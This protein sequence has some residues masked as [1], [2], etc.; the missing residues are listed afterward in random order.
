MNKKKLLLYAVSLFLIGL[1]SCH[2]N[3][4]ASTV[5]PKTWNSNKDV[6]ESVQPGDDFYNYA[7]G[8]WLKANPLKDE[9]PSNGTND[10]LTALDNTRYNNLMSNPSDNFLVNINKSI[11]NTDLTE[12]NS[13]DEV[14][15]DLALIQNANTEQ[16]V[17]INMGKLLKKGY[18]PVFS[19]SIVPN[20]STFYPY[21]QPGYYSPLIKN[22]QQ[23]V[24]KQW[25]AYCFEAFGYDSETATQKAE[26]AVNIELYMRKTE[27]DDAKDSKYWMK[28]EHYKNLH[29]VL[30]VT[31]RASESDISNLIKNAG[32]SKDVITQ[33]TTLLNMMKDVDW[34]TLKAYVENCVIQMNLDCLPSSFLTKYKEITGEEAYPVSYT[35]KNVLK[36]NM[37]YYINK[38]YTAKYKDEKIK[39]EVDEMTKNIKATF[40]RRIENSTW[41]SSATKT[42]AEAKLDAMIFNIGYPDS[43]ED[44][45]APTIDPTKCL[46]ANMK[47]CREFAYKFN[48]LDLVGKDKRDIKS[49]WRYMLCNNQSMINSAGYYPNFNALII[50]IGIM[51]KPIYIQGESDAYNY[52]TMG[53]TTIGHEM[54]H[55]FD[56]NG[57]EFN[58][59]GV[60]E[61]WW[62]AADKTVFEQKQKMLISV[63]NNIKVIGDVCVNGKKTLSENMAD[64]GG[65]E[66]AY[67]ALVEKRESE[68]Y[69][70]EGLIDQKKK[71]FYA[72]AEAWR[73]NTSDMYL[74]LQL[75]WDVHAPAKARV[76]GNVIN[77]DEW[78]ELFGVNEKSSMYLPT[79]KRVHIW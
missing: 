57:A 42:R 38:L 44:N 15:E 22:E 16:D 47:Q 6:D 45:C 26:K 19:V 31:S 67:Q 17:Y 43:W 21:F 64:L 74:L 52:A 65:L 7:V 14:K 70:D 68:G 25:V 11:T 58:E 51:D 13:L 72:F 9:E 73:G 37:M 29:R 77:S 53:A 40:K 3:D 71:F 24:Y 5:D 28:A 32:L 18:K 27:K 79:D 1:T 23:A 50:L 66:I 60:R 12:K 55:G 59:E 62:T 30:D 54:T 36:A 61:D 69:R 39:T 34:E 75:A 46:C 33:Q 76:N 41:M 20:N 78:Y 4:I 49:L 8:S 48:I 63:F 10:E 35:V 56:S 2:D